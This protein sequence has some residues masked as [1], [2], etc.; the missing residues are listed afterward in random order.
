MADSKKGIKKVGDF[1]LFHTLEFHLFVAVLGI[2]FIPFFYIFI[3]MTFH[4]LLDLYDLIKRN[5][6]Y[7]REYFLLNWIRRAL[8]SK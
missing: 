1:Y 3:G 4:S 8:F 2:F 6:M 7:A 5:Q